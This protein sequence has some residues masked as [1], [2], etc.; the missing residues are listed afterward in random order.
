M[1]ED[2]GYRI[3][4]TDEQLD[5][6]VDQLLD[7][8]RYAIDTEFHRE[9]TYY[10]Q[11]ALIQI[12]W[13]GD[14]VLIDPI[15]VD[16]EPLAE[17]FRSTDV[18]AVLHAC[19]QDLE[20]LE[21]VAGAAPSRLFDTQIAAAF[22][23][24]RTPS[25]ASL[26]DQLLGLKLPKANRLTDWLRRPLEPEQQ[27]YAASDVAHLLE[28]QDLLIDQLE[29]N[30]R[31][32]WADDECEL[33]RTKGLSVRKP[34]EA[35]L[36]IKEARSLGARARTAA[37]QLAAWRERSAQDRNIPVRHVLPD[38]AIV[39]LAQKAPSDPADVGRTR[40]LERRGVSKRDAAEIV[41]VISEAKDMPPPP[42]QPRKANG[43]PDLRPAVTL[44]AAWMS[45]YADDMNLDPAMLGSRSDI[46]EFVRSG[47]SRLAHGWR[48][49]LAGSAI[50][51]LLAGDAAVAFDGDGRVIVEKRSHVPIDG[52]NFAG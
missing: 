12:A 16:P 11:L 19:S 41:E 33:A 28:I 49:D 7:T 39:A 32:A 38:L 42:T 36:R 50:R 15:A 14:L 27:A 37:Q 26:H 29:D 47:E 52:D 10:P 23:G 46:E 51:S 21:L 45:Q 17:V 48:H 30:G 18:E 25:L 31:L 5:E 20:V 6:V 35:W 9:R 22:V 24:M 3:V 43:G 40:G 2:P 8:D 4:D 44:I 34:E 1:P 13:P